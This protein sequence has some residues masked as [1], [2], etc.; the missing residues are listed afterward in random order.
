MPWAIPTYSA[1][2][3]ISEK[4]KLTEDSDAIQTLSLTSEN[5]WKVSTHLS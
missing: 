4:K 5:D 2:R 1:T 3:D